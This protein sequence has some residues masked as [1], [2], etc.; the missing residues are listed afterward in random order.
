[1]SS[2]EDKTL[3]QIEVS[4]QVNATYRLK[5]RSGD[6][7]LENIRGN[8]LFV[9]DGCGNFAIDTDMCERQGIQVQDVWHY[10]GPSP[11]GKQKVSREW[12]VCEL[13]GEG[14]DDE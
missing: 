7:A 3:Y 11:T 8:S 1:M 9:E 10:S 5:A 13:A 2:K 12:D 14:W 4:Y 6:E